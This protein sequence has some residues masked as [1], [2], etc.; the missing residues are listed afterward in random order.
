MLEEMGFS[1]DAVYDEKASET[2]NLSLKIVK[3][4]R[5]LVTRQRHLV[6]IASSIYEQEIAETME[7]WGLLHGWDYLAFDEFLLQLGRSYLSF[8]ASDFQNQ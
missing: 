1:I 2:A 6:L 3:P 7:S 4:C 8:M 5:S